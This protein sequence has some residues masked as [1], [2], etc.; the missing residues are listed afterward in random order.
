MLPPDLLADLPDNLSRRALDDLL[1]ILRGS[2]QEWGITTARRSR[3][4]LVRR[5]REI[6]TGTAIGHSRPD[7]R[8]QVPTLFVVEAPW[9]IAYHPT[10]REIYRI[11]H[12]ARDF[13]ALFSSGRPTAGRG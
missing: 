10:T 1:G 13:P 8:P 5:C 3:N 11:V 12:G 6:G 7:V 2:A 4:R 9:V